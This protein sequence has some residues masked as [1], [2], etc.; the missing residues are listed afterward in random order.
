[1]T[2]SRH[3]VDKPR[4]ARAMRCPETCAF[5][6]RLALSFLGLALGALLAQGPPRPGGGAP[7][8][9]GGAPPGGVRPEG[10]PPGGAVP[11]GAPEGPGAR[12]SRGPGGPMA[13]ERRIL[14]EFDADGDGRLDAGERKA[15]RKTLEAQR[16]DGERRGRGP[17]GPR[18][19]MPPARPGRRLAPSDVPKYPGRGLFDT[20]ILRTLFLQ[21]ESADWE[22]ELAAFYRTDVEVP[23]RL[24][25]DGREVGEVGV[26]FRGSSSYF[27]VPAGY[28]RSLNVSIDFGGKQQRLDDVRTLNLLNAHGDPSFL[29]TVLACH[30]S[31]TRIPAP[32]AN[33]VRVVINGE[34]WGIYAN[35]EQFNGDFVARSF[36]TSS[37]ARW[38]V[39]GSPGGAGGLE[40]LGEDVEA[41]RQRYQIR[42]KDREEDW[43][44]LIELCRVLTQAPLEELE[45]R[46]APILDL[47]GVLWFLALDLALIN[48]DGYWVRA[49]DYNL[50]RDPKGVFHL[51]PYDLNETFAPA[52]GGPG[53]GA[54]WGRPG[55]EGLPPGP[56]PDGQGPPPL[57]PRRGTPGG[58]GFALDPLAGLDD[59]R[60]PLRSRLL[61]VP[62]LRARYLERVRAI[63][64][65]DLDWA[66]L[67]P[68][69]ERLSSLIEKDVGLDT[70]KL[71]SLDEFR[72]AVA[73][74]AAQAAAGGPGGRRRPSLREFADS[75][76]KFLIG[77]K[78]AA[79]PAAG[80][81]SGEGDR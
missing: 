30:V 52:M 21:F 80:S 75:R 35:V 20:S 22:E 43:K 79:E 66:R 48:N 15:A 60:K 59:P 17:G 10:S 67:G 49:S 63:A 56:P 69:V 73:P 44:A 27:M 72:A 31:G 6:R 4:P 24:V 40:F 3:G 57:V 58:A 77:W 38:K 33:L 78:D 74:T 76:R 55:G 16:G 54:P 81:P 12:P 42:S 5:V 36:G 18:E 51:I 47:D 1:M 50:Y 53:M 70:R 68:L 28:K 2:R 19:E 46:L 39:K 65:N 8:R 62:A 34:C 41:Y 11:G 13:P 45:A 64:Q 71:H 29:R 25:V 9:P 7:P 26:S 23:A 37:G 14:K 61:Q 32:R